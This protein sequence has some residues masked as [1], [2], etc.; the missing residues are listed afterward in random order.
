MKKNL[1]KLLSILML[2]PVF[3]IFTLQPVA[4]A[5]KSSLH[6][7]NPG[8]VDLKGESAG[9][10]KDDRPYIPGELIVMY[11]K[12]TSEKTKSGKYAKHKF[13][14]KK[15]L[16]NFN[17][18][19]LT[20]PV[21]ISVE[22]AIALFAADPDVLYVEPNYVVVPH[23]I[24]ND[25]DF[26][27]KWD[28]AN[29]MAPQAWDIT[30]GGSDVVVAVIDSGVDY[31]HEDL[32]ANMWNNPAELNGLTGVDDDG[33]GYVDDIYGI[34]P[35]DGGTPFSH[36]YH[37]T[38]VAGIIGAVGN[39][40]AGITGINWD[41]GIMACRGTP[42]WSNVY[43]CLDYIKT[44][45][46]QYGVNIVASNNSYEMMPSPILD[47][48]IRGQ[49]ESD[50]LFIASAGNSG[51][52]RD[53]Y[54]AYPNWLPNVITVAMTGSDGERHQA[55]YGLYTIDTAAPGSSVLTTYL[56]NGYGYPSGTSFSTPQVTG[57]AALIKSAEPEIAGF[58]SDDISVTKSDCLYN[59]LTWT[60]IPAHCSNRAHA[61]PLSCLNGG[62]IWTEEGTFNWIDIKNRILAGGDY[63][64]S[65][66]DKTVTGK[67]INAYRA[68]TC[69]DDSV[70]ALRNKDQK[71][72][73]VGHPYTVSVLSFDCL[74]P[75][76]VSAVTAN[77]E[78]LDL[79]DDG[80]APDLAAGDGVFTG[81][82][83]PENLGEQLILTSAAG[84]LTED[85][86]FAPKNSLTFDW[87]QDFADTT[88]GE[89]NFD[90]D[91]NVVVMLT[92]SSGGTT[93]AEVVKYD[94]AGNRIATVMNVSGSG[95]V[96]L[97]P[98][99]NILLATA[100]WGGYSL[101]I[102]K[103]APDGSLL[104]SVV[105][106]VAYSI[107]GITSIDADLAG[108]VYVVGICNDSS[109]I[110]SWFIHKYNA[111][112]N[113]MLWERVYTPQG[114]YYGK[115][116]AINDVELDSQ[117]NLFLTG[118]VYK[119]FGG[120][121]Y[122]YDDITIKFDKDSGE[123]AWQRTLSAPNSGDNRGWGLAID[124][125]D[126]LYLVMQQSQHNVPLQTYDS[127]FSKIAKI[128]SAGQGEPFWTTCVDLRL[129][130]DTAQEIDLD[131]HGLPVAF[132]N[133]IL[134]V[135]Y[136]S[137]RPELWFLQRVEGLDLSAGV[138]AIS[139]RRVKI[140]KNTGDIY[141]TGH[142]AI[143][144]KTFLAKYRHAGL[145]I[146]T[147]FPA[148]MAAGVAQN[149]QLSAGGESIAPLTWSLA[150]GTLPP[151]LDLDAGTGAI[152][153]TPVSPGAYTFTVAV[154][155]Y[156]A[157]TANLEISTTVLAPLVIQTGAIND[158]PTESYFSQT[159]SGS[160]G[161]HSYLWSIA[162]GA[163]P[164]GLALSSDGLLAGTP[165][166]PGTFTFT[167]RLRDAR[168]PE[169]P[170]AEKV[171]SQSIISAVKILTDSLPS[172]VNGHFYSQTLA[173]SGGNGSYTWSSPQFP[174]L[175]L[176]LS[177]NGVI[178]G[179]PDY[180]GWSSFGFE[181]AA[182]SQNL[183]VYK[184]LSIWIAD[185]LTVEIATPSQVVVGDCCYNLGVGVSGGVAPYSL[186]VTGG[187]LPPG[188]EFDS[189]H[190]AF[191]GSPTVPGDYSFTLQITDAGGQV[192]NQAVTIS[193]LAVE[194]VMNAVSIVANGND[195][196][197][198]FTLVRQLLNGNLGVNFYLS[199]DPDISGTDYS[200]G[201][202]TIYTRDEGSLG[203][204]SSS[205]PVRIGTDLPS[206]DYYIG[207]I[208][209][210]DNGIL[211][212]DES[213]NIALGNQI[214]HVGRPDL[215]GW[216]L[217]GYTSYVTGGTY[218]LPITVAN[219]SL[220]PSSQ[221][222]AKLYLST[223][224]EITSADT[225]VG[226]YEI[227]PLQDWGATTLN[228]S[229]QIPLVGPG[230]YFLGVILDS[231]NLIDEADEAN[232]V[233]SIPAVVTAGYPDMV[234]NSASLPPAVL[235]AGQ[236]VPVQWSFSLLNQGADLSGGGEIGLY[237]SVDPQI[238]A[239]DYFVGSVGF[240]SL[241]ASQTFDTMIDW[242][243][244][245]WNIPVGN[246]YLGIVGDNTHLSLESNENNND[247]VTATAME[248]ISRELQSTVPFGIVSGNQISV[249]FAVL[250]K[251]SEPVGSTV[252]AVYLSS[253]T[254]VP[255]EDILLGTVTIPELASGE[256]LLVSGA[257]FV[258]STGTIPSGEYNLA[259]VADIDNTVPEANEDNAV[260][261]NRIVIST[262]ERPLNLS[263][264]AGEILPT[265]M[266]EL[267]TSTFS[268]PMGG[269]GH[270]ASRWQ[271]A[272][273]SDFTADGVQGEINSDTG[274]VRYDLS[275]V[276][277]FFGRDIVRICAHPYGEID[278]MEADDV[279][280]PNSSM[281]HDNRNY[282][283]RGLDV[284]WAQN[285]DLDT[286]F[287][288]LK[289]FDRGSHV[290]VEWLASTWDDRGDF[291]N[292]KVHHQVLI[293]PDG[294]ITWNL[295]QMDWSK[296]NGGMFT[297]LYA[298]D[299]NREIAIG[300]AINNQ[301]SY[302]FDPGTQE[303]SQAAFTWDEPVN[304]FLYDS[305]ETNQD[306]TMHQV[307][308][309]AAMTEGIKYWRVRYLSSNNEWSDW[310]MP[311]SF[312][313][314]N[315]MGQPLSDYYL[316]LDGDGFGDSAAIIQRCVAPAGY[317][318]V[319]GDC[320]DSRASSS[321]GA[322][323]VCDMIDN[324][325]NGI[326]DEGCLLIKQQYPGPGAESCPPNIDSHG[327]VTWIG[328]GGALYLDYASGE[329]SE[330]PV[331]GCPTLSDNGMVGWVFNDGSNY[332]IGNY[333]IETGEKNTIWSVPSAQ[334]VAGLKTNA[335]GDLAWRAGAYND[336][337]FFD[338]NSQTTYQ[339]TNN[340]ASNSYD[341]EL[342]DSG[343]LVWVINWGEM[344][345]YH[346]ATGNTVQIAS[347]VTP[348][349]GNGPKLNNNGDIVWSQND[350]SD[351]EIYQYQAATGV[352]TQLT[353]NSF[354]DIFPTIN[355]S[356]QIAWQ[357]NDGA[358]KRIM[359]AS[360]ANIRQIATAGHA[361]GPI[362]INNGGDMVW[363]GSDYPSNT[364]ADEEVFYYHAATDKVFQVS[365]NDFRDRGPNVNDAGQMVWLS[366]IYGFTSHGF[367]MMMADPNFADCDGDGIL[368][369]ADNCPQFQGTSEQDEDGDGIVDLIDNCPLMS[370][371]SQADIDNDGF[372]DVCD[373][374][375]D[376][377]G[378]G[379]QIETQYCG[380]PDCDD[381]D[382]T[383]KPYGEE[384]CDGK[385][386]NCDGAIDE[387]LSSCSH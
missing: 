155:D 262:V 259:V 22:E 233:M 182:S 260:V 346:A 19:H 216:W 101:T 270:L 168:Y 343:D 6:E 224:E 91:N 123:V 252:A 386:N 48:A 151:G 240:P 295:K 256:S 358:T 118:T 205:F 14:R 230:G 124:A 85:F 136:N 42:G 276:F 119:G 336:L 370:N 96:T 213:N 102:S 130:Y 282:L 245:P 374:C 371:S 84:S 144:Q 141:L 163:L 29:V 129:L 324:N 271:V 189:V 51:Y 134:M 61:D 187:S 178:S 323:E 11:K 265:I 3:V 277:P 72:G 236:A 319:G 44:M 58:C 355:D 379:Y 45:K 294:T 149:F 303:A 302:V 377:D 161:S 36:S 266:P 368:D 316:D 241:A 135:N 382:P 291:T 361:M 86:A 16:K 8:R 34:D 268:D 378:D 308:A 362:T 156:A 177:S 208:A 221:A 120:S 95:K 356:S 31:T 243:G 200:L 320:N 70:L 80:V 73:I 93:T 196:V 373:G 113:G 173:A 152:S 50:I 269:G 57:L 278:L 21:G 63:K 338:I 353:N 38:A 301:S 68:L 56:N 142:S 17:I 126:E 169:A 184:Y 340:N 181:V 220:T 352:I 225:L 248:V 127:D 183:T 171:F 212:A 341:F 344:Y 62:A 100:T 190:R 166:D 167:V 239:T 107:E 65:L 254:Y 198:D 30:T 372:G 27:D 139:G 69:S 25:P 313:A 347:G 112:L 349:Y 147:S 305:G 232:N 234:I 322:L 75:L 170:P 1:A 222:S 5:S 383:V 137:A 376:A 37:G 204:Y 290:L 310:S 387:N 12:G 284:I 116:C 251:G 311:T 185:P 128:D 105:Q 223:D 175:G 287:G 348:V 315:C 191:G 314:Y 32:V 255:D 88:F 53:P 203:V 115:Y 359:S 146:F 384:I 104:D 83:L 280:D 23:A 154:T 264:A 114:K 279:C 188:I 247:L 288:Y 9:Y 250:N 335:R 150:G 235:E 257:T 275:F 219:Q 64:T 40:G 272:E 328:T 164:P 292:H 199:S 365:D 339:I 179:T 312:A 228:Q 327:N 206:G 381:S 375:T 7:D 300:S 267:A 71:G 242:F 246:Y 122:N 249:D 20:V 52:S 304:T 330:I 60:P 76:P 195:A 172:A 13:G 39:N 237:L 74:G 98:S 4:A 363:W 364:G 385:D 231:D 202:Y 158:L 309:A 293:Y 55:D 49:M 329:I 186:A 110:K 194:V 99:Y 286:T 332:S 274:T 298:A 333:N 148:E 24:P 92:H 307:P 253:D 201:Q 360:G 354:D 97:D 90:Q 345:F 297:G 263:P 214:T 367:A 81:T 78:V 285:G 238:D 217:S 67:Q 334:Y 211:E 140:N 26:Q 165:T 192:V 79:R 54:V 281:L 103:H 174:L 337:F 159:L 258:P 306:L 106:P 229:L 210:P 218:D 351:N 162:A 180:Q 15:K 87:R 244:L 299:E 321:P 77:N 133:D 46:D 176:T 215:T 197:I 43:A 41:V 94:P 289:V 33:N 326:I 153:G 331:P 47:E 89:L 66:L 109:S 117:G 35:E 193:V 28:L 143:T 138:N 59:N 207:A 350:G 380:V 317:V 296:P 111:N 132:V 227:P 157:S 318:T 2:F 125:N 226:S 273:R 357:G 82:W 325:C 261:G 342:N 18:D 369:I 121:G 283:G 131:G 145:H 160:G 108:N 366:R 209:D 10:G